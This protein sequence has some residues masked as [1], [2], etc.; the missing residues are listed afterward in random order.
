MRG[1]LSLGLKRK[2]TCGSGEL[3]AKKGGS[4]GLGRVQRTQVAGIGS[5]AG[6]KRPLGGVE[7][8]DWRGRPPPPRGSPVLGKGSAWRAPGARGLKGPA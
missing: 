5:A 3:H 1:R 4:H 7:G 6:W 2:K 8:V